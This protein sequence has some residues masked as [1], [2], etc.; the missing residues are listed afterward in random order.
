MDLQVLPLLEEGI[1]KTHT[2]HQVPRLLMEVAIKI[3][4]DPPVLLQLEV[5]AKVMDLLFQLQFQLLPPLQ[6]E[7]HMVPPVLHPCSLVM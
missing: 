1:T 5:V 7:T 3:P 2:D 6:L 4:M